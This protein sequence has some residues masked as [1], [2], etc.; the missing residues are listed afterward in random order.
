MDFTKTHLHW[1]SIRIFTW[2]FLIC[3][4]AAASGSSNVAILKYSLPDHDMS[5]VENITEGLVNKG[6]TVN[7]LTPAQAA[8]PSVLSADKFCLYIVPNATCYPAIAFENLKTYLKNK[9]NILLLSGSVFQQFLVECQ[10]KWVDEKILKD[11]LVKNETQ[12]TIFDFENTADVN[13]DRMSYTRDF[14]SEIAVAQGGVNGS[15]CLK[16]LISN[17][18]GWDLYKIPDGKIVFNSDQDVLTFWAK[19]DKATPSL[20]VEIRE[21]DYSR[22][23]A[24][25]ELT[26]DW[27][28]YVVIPEDFKFWQHDS[29][30][31]R[32]F[33][34]DHLNFQNVSTIH[35]GLT[36]THTKISKGQHVVYIDNI[37]TMSNPFK[38][39]KFASR[40]EIAPIETL[41]PTYKG[42]GLE[43]FDSIK[44]R[45]EN[46]NSIDYNESFKSAWCSQKRTAST[47]LSG[48]PKFRYIP[49]AEAFDK[50]GNRKGTIA[51]ILLNRLGEFDGAAFACIGLNDLDKYKDKPVIEIISQIAE[52][53]RDGL[54]LYRAGA[55]HFSY[56]AGQKVK[57]GCEIINRTKES[58]D[59]EI[60]ITVASDGKIVF[61]DTRT[62]SIPAI[63]QKEL[64]VDYQLPDASDK[65]FNVKVELV[66]DGKV[67]DSLSHELA[68]LENIKHTKDEFVTVKGSDFYLKGQ[69]WYPVGVNYWPQYVSGLDRNIYWSNWLKP[70][71]YDPSLI[72]EDLALMQQLGINMVSIQIK[73]CESGYNL[74][75]FLKR[76]EK[77]NIRANLA[78]VEGVSTSP[79]NF[80]PT[81]AEK[82][83][84]DFD[85]ANN[86]AIFAYDIIWEPGNYVFCKP[87]RVKYN[88]NWYQWVIERYG[89]VANAEIDWNYK[90]T[91]ETGEIT[92]PSDEQLKE[93]GD[94]R[95]M[96]AAYRRFMD[97]FMSKTWNIATQKLRELLPNQLISYR[98]GNT[99]PHDFT[100]TATAKHVDFFCP[101]G[102][103]IAGGEDGFNTACFLSRYIDFIT[104]GKPIIWSEF[105]VSVW[106]NI[107]D[108][109]TQ[110]RI[111]Y[112]TYYNEMFYKVVLETG[113]NGIA[114]WWW[115]GGFREGEYSDYGL[116]N[117]DGTPRPSIQ[118]LEKYAP[119]MKTHRNRPKT[120]EFITIDRD[121]N[122]GGYWYLAF[123]EGKDKYAKLRKDGKMMGIKTDGTGTDSANTPLLAVGNTKYTGSNPPKFLNSEFNYFK[124]KDES[125]NW[126]DVKKGDIVSVTKN[127]PVLAKASVGNLQEAKWLCPQNASINL[128]GVYLTS[129]NASALQVKIPIAKDVN[130]LEDAVIDEFTL[131]ES[132]ITETK[133]FLQMA[134]DKR[135]YF[136][137]ILDF[138]LLP[139]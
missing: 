27:K 123:Y 18:Q 134:A 13:W 12:N 76:C 58:K 124:I 127:Q 30:K 131:T 101:E 119:M 63:G 62:E 55:E 73:D 8:D 28:K 34:G 35:I 24:V 130:Y 56:Q 64:F 98:Q 29:P 26:E 90:I 126:V 129:T 22:W 67:I 89:S 137:E 103:A 66:K 104:G 33:A 15:N 118:L 10:G 5:F 46:F 133:A 36:L 25:V 86:P 92:H 49:L 81:E 121:G 97:D 3:I 23:F 9:G 85:L 77:R 71:Q 82:L 52:S 110:P 44:G 138:T 122:S 41:V 11:L 100:I 16:M 37:G 45:S 14:S 53:F 61:E 78:M 115:P 68:A 116:L 54:F 31:T 42:Y 99:L 105:G 136:G 6:F 57:L 102:Y 60:K 109:P 94:Y 70:G 128:G 111:D 96:V 47:G 20:A 79:L 91:G 114:P 38:V 139:K 88:D 21:H 93:D 51:W 17:L 117:L 106:D 113:C 43:N 84:K 108:V 69:K 83:I 32:G 19:G 75:D 87:N 65:L 48:N 120:D 7:C 132:L 112:Q 135:A 39:D 59:A 72:E 50:A 125:G 80:D 4:V 74:V 1:G 40:Q 107:K 95:I 2:I